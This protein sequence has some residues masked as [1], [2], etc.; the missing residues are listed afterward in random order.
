MTK[1]SII[2]GLPF[3]SATLE[4]NGQILKLERV[5]IDNGSGASLFKTDDLATIG[6]SITSSDKLEY[7]RG[8]GGQEV[9]VSKQI[10]SLSV[11]SMTVKPFIIQIGGLAYGAQMDGIIGAD[12]LLATGAK[13]DFENLTI[14]P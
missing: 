1:I 2:G 8:I 12:F 10:S 6:I 4:A 7:M 3:T 14:N 13:I 5:L 11:G 9:V